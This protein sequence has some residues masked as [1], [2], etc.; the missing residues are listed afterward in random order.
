[1]SV[2]PLIVLDTNW[3]PLSNSMTSGNP[4]QQKMPIRAV[5]TDSA[6]MYFKGTASTH[7]EHVSIRLRMKRC[8]RAD[9]W[10]NSPTMS[11]ATR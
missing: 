5:A 10:C 1:M 11:I 4:M 6:A 3:V 8:P 7:L 2:K 9:I